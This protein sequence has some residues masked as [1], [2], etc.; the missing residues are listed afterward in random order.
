[1]SAAETNPPIDVPDRVNMATWFLDARLDE[2]R[3]EQ[4]AV[5]YE[6]KDARETWTYA[7]LVEAS[8]R[9]TNLLRAHDLRIEDRVQLL[10]L[11][12]PEFVTSYFGILRAGCVAVPTNTW[13]KTKDYAYYLEYARPRAVFV[14]ASVWPEFEP[15][16]PAARHRPL[17]FYVDRTG[18]PAPEGTID[19][20]AAAAE[21]PAETETEPTY[22]DD[23]ATWLSSSGSTG[24]PKCVVHMH[25]D[26]IWNTVAYAQRTLGLKP[27]DITMGAPKLF[28]G[29]ALASNMLF[30][31]SVG[32]SCVLLPERVAAEDY[33]EL[34]ERYKVTQFVT[35]PTTIAKM[36]A[37]ADRAEGRDLSALHSLISAGEALPPRV[38]KTWHERFDAE[39]Y[40]G[41]GSAEMFH[42][43]ITNRPGDVKVGSLG[44]LV[45]GY[46]Y[47]LVD[48]AGKQ[49]PAGEIGTL[50]IKGPSAGLGYWRM[51]DKS[52]ETFFGDAVKGGDKFFVDEAGYF[53]YCGRG[54]DMLKCSGVYV[55]P[56]EVEDAV[57]GHASVR[58]AGVAG[59][60]DEA[61]LEKAMAFVELNEGFA[62]S[63]DLAE[64]I[65]AHVRN[66]I[67]AFKAPRKV[68]FV[69]E[70]P[71]TET[72]KIR[73]ARLRELAAE[74]NP[75]SAS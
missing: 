10:L 16:L 36:L 60:R 69:D 71:R 26:F 32:G 57:M 18:G 63:D 29:Y 41:I 19:M 39:I 54:D 17:I 13:L 51:R 22:R 64:A 33:F 73:R 27:T 11:D 23:F 5:Y 59:F 52:R 75:E 34:L 72:G 70:L 55:S 43:Y 3:G 49:V 14:D 35:V 48:D 45:Q 40:D 37:A 42:V 66:H 31:F 1:M 12:T 6:G 44:K 65:V 46:S 47:E 20:L 2:G 67:A 38:C 61:G 4:V 50:V 56:V 7:A 8:R 9:I 28:F 25:H 62:G 21:Q 53:W 74:M 24:N 15:A 68:V 30:P 58:E